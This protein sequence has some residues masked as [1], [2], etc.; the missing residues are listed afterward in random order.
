M[1]TVSEP[2]VTVAVSE[3]RLHQVILPISQSVHND[4]ACVADHHI[5]ESLLDIMQSL[6]VTKQS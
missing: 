4:E 5:K 3:K 1:P 6:L 2:R